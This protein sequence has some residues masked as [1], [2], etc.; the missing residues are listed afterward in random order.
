MGG[1][2]GDF[3]N[4]YTKI[5]TI[6]SS[7]ATSTNPLSL[8]A[9]LSTPVSGYYLSG[10]VYRQGTYGLFWSSTYYSADGM[11]SMRVSGTGVTPQNSN[12]RFYGFSVRCIVQR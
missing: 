10:T 4:L 7:A 9:M 1:A 3:Q 2:S 11:Y 8:Q 5:G 12:Y 6:T